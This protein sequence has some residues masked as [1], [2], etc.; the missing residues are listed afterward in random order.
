MLEDDGL[1]VMYD[2]VVLVVL[3]YGVGKYCVFDV[4]VDMYQIID[5]VGVVDM[6]DVLFDDGFFVENFGYVVGGCVDQ[7][8]VVFLCVLVWGCV[9]EGW[10]E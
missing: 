3:E 1:V 2:D 8:D 7:F 10:K 6:N 9:G 5:G 4:G